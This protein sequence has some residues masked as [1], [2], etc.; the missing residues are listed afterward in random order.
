M[1]LPMTFQMVLQALDNKGASDS[2]RKKEK[3]LLKT[4]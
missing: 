2:I 1:A 3:W 4:E